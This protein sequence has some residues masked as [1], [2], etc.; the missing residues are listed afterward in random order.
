MK[1]LVV[2]PPSIY[3]VGTLSLYTPVPDLDQD[4]PYGTVCTMW[5]VV[6]PFP[7]RPYPTWTVMSTSQERRRWGGKEEDGDVGKEVSFGEK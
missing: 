3:Q 6:S 2:T 1:F 4:I 5:Y 7:T